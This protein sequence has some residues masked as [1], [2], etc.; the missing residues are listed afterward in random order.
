ML[1]NQSARIASHIRSDMH[2]HRRFSLSG[3]NLF[4]TLI[5]LRDLHTKDD[6]QPVDSSMSLGIHSFPCHLTSENN[7][8]TSHTS[9]SSTLPYCFRLCILYPAKSHCP[10]STLIPKHAFLSITPPS[11]TSHRFLGNLGT[12]TI[13]K[14]CLFFKG[15]G[16]GLQLP[17]PAP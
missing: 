5:R 1:A 13:K 12:P 11:S 2:I 14:P 15:S 7:R 4:S 8:T 16:S 9:F 17:S 6:S 3:V 10:W